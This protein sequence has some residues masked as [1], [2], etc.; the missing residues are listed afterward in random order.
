[1][2]AVQEP[3]FAAL[4]RMRAV[5][6]EKPGGPSMLRLCTRPVPQPNYGD[7]VIKLAY[8]G[9]NRPDAL[10]RAGLYDPPAGASDLPG[11]EASGT[12]CALGAGVHNLQLALLHGEVD[13]NVRTLGHNR[14]TTLNRTPSMLVRPQAE[15]I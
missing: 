4:S 15:T 14:D 2:S 11:L 9:V 10:Q 7:V 8:A 6:I 13:H 3:E 5:E 1:M 12:I